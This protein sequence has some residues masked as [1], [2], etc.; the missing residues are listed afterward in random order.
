MQC[1]ITLYQFAKGLREIVL[2]QKVIG[3]PFEPFACGI[4]KL[5]ATPSM[6]AI[7]RWKNIILNK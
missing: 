3:Y 7:Y 1:S 2:L 5:H 6:P 4:R